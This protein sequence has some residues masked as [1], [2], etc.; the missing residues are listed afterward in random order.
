MLR[1]TALLTVL[2]GSLGMGTAAAQTSGNSMGN[3][4]GNTMAPMS[5]PAMATTTAKGPTLVNPQGRTLYTYDNDKSD[6][7]MCNGSCAKLWPPFL[8]PANATA[9]GNWSIITRKSGAKQWAYKG[10]PLYTWS[11]DMKA[12][13]TS[14]SGIK[15]VWHVA[16]P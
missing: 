12:G 14:G 11:K 2:L 9:S 10:M 6:Q 7:S 15:G 1:N 5:A 4:M 13:D 3:S 8:A 16:H